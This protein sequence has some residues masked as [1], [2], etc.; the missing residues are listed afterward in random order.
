[1]G[2]TSGTR[3]GPYLV[4][5]PLGTGGMGEVYRATDTNLGRDVALKVLPETVAHDPERLAR[6]EREARTLASLS[7]PNIAI[8]HGL[9]KS[10]ET[11][12]LVMELVDGP[13]LADRIAGGPLQLDEALPVAR[14][15]ADALE[16]A[17]AQGIVHRDLKPANIKM[18]SDGTV[19]VL[20]FGLAKAF[21]TAAS[22]SSLQSLSPTITSPAHTLRGVILGTAAYMSPEQA[23]GRAVDQRADVWAFGCVLYEM[24]TGRRAFGPTALRREDGRTASLPGRSRSMPSPPAPDEDDD[25]SLTLARVLERDA[26]LTALPPEVPSRVRQAIAVCLRKDLRLRAQA[27]GDVRLALDG[28]FESDEPRA[29]PVPASRASWWPAAVALVAGGA[30]AAAGMLPLA[31]R[32]EAK[33]TVARFELHAPPGSRLPFGTPAISNDGRMLAYTVADADGTSRIHVRTIDRVDTRVLPGTEGAIHPFWSPDG[34][35]LA[36]ATQGE[37]Q[38]KRIDID[39]G[40]PRTLSGVTGPWHGTWAAGN[41]LLMAGSVP[42]RMRED[43]GSTEPVGRL[44]AESSERGVTYPFFLTDGRRF[45][46]RVANSKGSSIQLAAL[47]TMDRTMVLENVASAPLLAAT[48][49]GKT[50]LLYMRAPD[51]L[52]QEFDE[53]SGTVL[54]AA[55]V[56]IPGIGQV[57]SPPVRPSVGVSPAGI[58]AYQTGGIGTTGQL[59]WLDRLGKEVG[60]LSLDASVNRPRLSPDGTLLAGHRADDGQT[61]VWVTDLKRGTSTRLTFA[62][63]ARDAEWSPD[64]TKLAFRRT[65]GKVGIYVI[66]LD[67]SGERRVSEVSDVPQSWSPD[68]RHLLYDALTTLN[69]LAIDGTEKPVQVSSPNG[70]ASQAAFSPDGKYIAYRSDESGRFE[71]YVQATPPGRQRIKLSIDGGSNPRWR[72]DGGEIYFF[73]PAGALMAVDVTTGD[74]LTAGVPR[75]LFR[76][77]GRSAPAGF[78]VRA[79]GQRFLVPRLDLQDAPITVVLNWWADLE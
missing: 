38:L 39:G 11:L 57:A 54:G 50:Y 30:L 62:D 77:P 42:L 73:S 29:D 76:S 1:M 9:E 33:P 60:V 61:S 7:H 28:A 40:A 55:K 26:D 66:G 22:S 14:Q 75:E 37:S 68:G 45:L 67:G 64:G 56:L 53:R 79:D 17:H 18:R 27:I 3:F 43:G 47:G 36:F 21:D 71:V 19:K 16:A 58:I 52:V 69:I 13:T 10:G 48:P 46:V 12:A 4:S 8:V 41:I 63:N 25:V 6:F 44:N 72:R 20:D 59:A 74:R 15:I 2:V 34:R 70:R 24:L 65:T 5:E 23:R 49:T 51:L 78:D 32:P 31:L 35:A